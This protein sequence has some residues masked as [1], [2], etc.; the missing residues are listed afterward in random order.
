MCNQQRKYYIYTS[1]N[2]DSY[3]LHF[4]GLYSQVSCLTSHPSQQSLAK[5]ISFPFHSF[6]A[7]IL[8]F[9]SSYSSTLHFLFDINHISCFNLVLI[10]QPGPKWFLLLL[11]LFLNSQRCTQH[12]AVLKKVLV[13]GCFLFLRRFIDRTTNPYSMDAIKVKRLTPHMCGLWRIIY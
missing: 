7:S 1:W 4:M 3:F 13:N 6:V 8:L 2:I 11:Q 10:E 5:N 9:I 12:L